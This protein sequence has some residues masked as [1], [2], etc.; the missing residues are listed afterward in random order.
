[1][2]SSHRY[3]EPPLLVLDMHMLL[4]G[5]SS[6]NGTQGTFK[7][8][9]RTATCT[10]FQGQTIPATKKHKFWRKKIG[11]W[12]SATTC[13]NDLCQDL[14]GFALHISPQAVPNAGQDVSHH[15]DGHQHLPHREG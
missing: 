6:Q 10:N 1:M 12:D 15:P 3:G 9:K 11:R 2:L 5:Q 7:P 14:P 4:L 13:N 8:T